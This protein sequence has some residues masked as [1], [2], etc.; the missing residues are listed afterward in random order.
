MDINRYQLS[1]LEKKKKKKEK[2]DREKEEREER[3]KEKV[4]E[5]R[6]EKGEEKLLFLVVKRENYHKWKDFNLKTFLFLLK[7]Y[8]FVKII[9]AVTNESSCFI[10]IVKKKYEKPER[11]AGKL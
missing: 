7:R 1:R 2:E 4:K 3:R 5:K 8:Y 11:E 9:G 10:T 6:E